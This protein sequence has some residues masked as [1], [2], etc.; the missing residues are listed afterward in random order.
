[1]KNSKSNFGEPRELNWSSVYT[2]H[3]VRRAS[4][5]LKGIKA[6]KAMLVKAL[7]RRGRNS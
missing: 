6:E 5:L 4:K 3:L 1:M 7:S 2:L